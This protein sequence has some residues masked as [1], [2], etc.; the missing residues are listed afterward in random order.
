LT[1]FINDYG[2][3]FAYQRY[4]EFFSDD[5]TLVIVI[6]SS[7]RSRNLVN[8]VGWCIEKSIPYGVLTAFDS[9]NTIR[10]MS[11]DA[12][13]NYYIDTHS[14]GVAECVHQIFLH[15]VVECS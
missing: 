9:D 12:M 2:P 5:E 1:C 4:L 7:G 13:F 3:E 10:S 11:K 14:Y 6:S 8:A 15:G